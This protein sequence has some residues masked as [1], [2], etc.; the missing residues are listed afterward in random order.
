MSF[1]THVQVF[2]ESP[3]VFYYSLSNSLSIDEKSRRRKDFLFLNIRMFIIANLETLRKIEI[4]L[5]E[6]LLGMMKVHHLALPVLLVLRE[7]FSSL[8]TLEGPP[9]IW[10]QFGGL[11]EGVTAKI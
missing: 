4:S 1:Y 6:H 9:V 5:V 3:G 10:S 8:D 2:Y 11:D 7:V